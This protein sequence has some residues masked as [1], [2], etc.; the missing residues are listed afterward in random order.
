MNNARV[1]EVEGVRLRVL[2][3][4][5]EEAE[6][7]LLFNGAGTNALMWTPVMHRLAQRFRV[8]RHDY[9]GTGRSTAGASEDA[10]FDRYAH[11]AAAILDALG[12]SASIVWG[13]AF[14]SRVALTFAAVHQ[15]RVSIAALF[16]ASVLPPDREAQRK[17]AR[18]ARERRAAAGIEELQPDHDWRAHDDPA[19]AAHAFRNAVKGQPT[20]EHL[21]RDVTCPTLVATGEH[22]ANLSSSREMARDLADAELVVLDLVSHGSVWQRPDLVCST[23]LDF[24]ERRTCG[25]V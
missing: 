18:V 13:L 17:G 3:D 23:F 25:P 2:V 24:V 11:D 5:P 1:V 19:A 16:D 7:V 14:G 9:R 21:L 8:I 15:E 6:P 22:D 4:G 20:L 10:T 12:V